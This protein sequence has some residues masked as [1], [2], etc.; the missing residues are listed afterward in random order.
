MSVREKRLQNDYQALSKL[1]ADSAG[2]LKLISKEGNPPYKYV[3]EYQCN[4][5]EK[6]GFLGKPV[7]RNTHRVEITLGNNYPR[8]QPSA[9]F[10]TP[11][12]HPNVYQNN[13]VCLGSYWTMS[14]TLTELIFRIGKLIQ[15]SK[16]VTN[17]N[18]PAN[19]NARNWAGKNMSLF[20]VGVETFVKIHI[21]DK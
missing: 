5:V 13:N 4:G 3:I 21:R 2:T 18:S 8:E 20:P 1:I 19:V 6:L 7:Y 17:L 14:E 9:S 16:D 11:I 12:F 15:Y 10:L